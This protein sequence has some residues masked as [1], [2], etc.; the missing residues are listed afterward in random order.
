M[1]KI[2]ETDRAP[3]AIGPYSQA[4]A[5]DD[6]VFT[7]GQIAI[8]PKT[9]TLVQGNVTAQTRQ[10]LENLKAVIEAAG[11][12]IAS[13]VKTTVYLTKSEDFAVMNDVYA[14]YFNNEPP[15]RSTVFVTALP[16]GALV[17]IDII[18]KISRH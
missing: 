16:K 2:I 8:V 17:E 12:T 5:V 11:A 1:K 7:A 6:Y 10:V 3:K 4:V 13:V 14:E 18:A 9:N 15:A